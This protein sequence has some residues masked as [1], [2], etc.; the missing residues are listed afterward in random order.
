LPATW[1]PTWPPVTA[2]FCSSGFARS[3]TATPT[4]LSVKVLARAAGY[5]PEITPGEAE[6]A[7]DTGPRTGA[8][9]EDEGAGAW[10]VP[11]VPAVGVLVVVGT[12]AARVAGPTWAPSSWASR[13]RAA[14]RSTLPVA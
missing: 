14:A 3:K 5:A 7:G 6:G 1:T 9:E 8:A 12:P 13:A 2:S 11:A 4:A 10:R